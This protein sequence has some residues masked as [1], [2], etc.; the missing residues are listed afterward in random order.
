MPGGVADDLHIA[1]VGAVFA[2]IPQV[3]AGVRVGRAHPVGADQ[4]AVDGHVRP[5]LRPALLED[6]V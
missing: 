1:A 6:F 5:A 2:G 4:D 3:V